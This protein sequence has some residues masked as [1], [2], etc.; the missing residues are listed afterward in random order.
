MTPSKTSIYGRPYIV[1]PIGKYKTISSPLIEDIYTKIETLFNVEF[2][3]A[4]D[5]ESIKPE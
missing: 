2:G 3:R 1:F 5:I 4:V